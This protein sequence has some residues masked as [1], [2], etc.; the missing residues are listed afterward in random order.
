MIQA[1]KNIREP[2]AAFPVRQS[3][4][5]RAGNSIG[6]KLVNY[7][8][9]MLLVVSLVFFI[10][11]YFLSLQIEQGRVVL[12]QQQDQ[13]AVEKRKQAELAQE[14]NF[15]ISEKRIIP[16]AA[17]RLQLRRHKDQIHSL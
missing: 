14:K 13:L 12:N 8:A 7:L 1:V 16:Y 10:L 6:S 2:V 17:V 15:L 11:S 3:V 9:V 5:T 4:S